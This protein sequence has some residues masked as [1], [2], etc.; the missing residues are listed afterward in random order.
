MAQHEPVDPL[1][2]FDTLLTQELSVAPS[3]EF[4][5]RVRERIR[6]E[7]EPAR[8][9]R[10]WLAPLAAAAAILLAVF[11]RPLWVDPAPAA[12]TPAPDVHLA[13]TP[14]KSGERTANPPSRSALRWARSEERQP[15]VVVDERQRVALISMLRLINQGQ[16]TEESFKTTT[17]PPT[18]IGVEPVAV[19]PIV[20]G[21]VL[22]S[23]GERK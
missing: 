14:A 5:P 11:T 20:V 4:L 8:A 7:P 18:E 6:L 22:P 3:P 13:A 2:E 15:D 23:E 16:L 9:W 10:L 17:P 21:G 19:S 12:R 1:V